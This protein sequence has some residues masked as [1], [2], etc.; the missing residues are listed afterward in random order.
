M[1]AA[2]ET[3][4]ASAPDANPRDPYTTLG[5]P[6]GT[7]FDEIKLVYRRLVRDL[8]PDVNPEARERFDA[9]QAAF[10]SL[11]A[12]NTSSRRMLQAET[13]VDSPPYF[14]PR[15]CPAT[16]TAPDAQESAAS[17]A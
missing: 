8:H 10:E 11:R 4:S 16:A 6:P 1:Y 14:T 9:V 5:V 13:V 7:P 15:S 12:R 2:M 3:M 17:H